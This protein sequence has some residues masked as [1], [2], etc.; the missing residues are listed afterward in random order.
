MAF[1]TIIAM[2]KKNFNCAIVKNKTK[3]DEQ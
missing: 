3:L 2:V 1:Y